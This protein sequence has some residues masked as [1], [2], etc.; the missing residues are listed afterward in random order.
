ME[1]PIRGVDWPRQKEPIH[2]RFDNY[3]DAVRK[4]LSLPS[5]GVLRGRQ[6]ESH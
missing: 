1:H 2:K 5:L 6:I 4:D 3:V